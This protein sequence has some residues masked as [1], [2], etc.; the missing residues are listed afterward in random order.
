MSTYTADRLG[1][2][3]ENDSAQD[4]ILEKLYGSVT[5]RAI[6]KPLVNPV[7]SEL[8]GRLLDSRISALAVPVF[9]RHAGINLWEYEPQRYCSYNE[10]FTRQIR[11]DA[12]KIDMVP[13]HFVSPCDSRVSV[14]PIDEKCCVKIKHTPYTVAELL[15]NPVLAKRYEGG[16]LWVF[17][18]CVDDYHHYI[19]IDDGFES[20]RVHIPGVL[21]TVNPVANDVYPIYKENTREY[22][23]LKTMNFGTVLMMEVGAL[24]V[25]RIEN[26]PLR[27][28]VRR[29]KEKGNFAFGGSTIVLMTQKNR[30]M[31]DPDIFINSEKGIE[32][33]VRLG[34][35][36]GVSEVKNS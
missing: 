5:G 26:V 25:G 7:L 8:G 6:L 10:F 29:G 21:H 9:I 32:T 15:K 14:Y 27:G 4:R 18:L 17:R 20:R 24:M 1:Y 22:A 31:P 12:R 35:K 11:E 36:I 3:Q 23:L 33:R 28:R 19:Y 30:V 16:Y 34:E 13:E 2:V